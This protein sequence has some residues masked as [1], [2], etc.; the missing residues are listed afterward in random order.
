MIFVI[1]TNNCTL[2]HT[3]TEADPASA[4]V[5]FRSAEELA[6]IVADWP[7][8]RLVTLWNN[9]PGV[10]P[11]HRFTD[12]QTAVRRIWT[13]V[14]PATSTE[15]KANRSDQSHTSGSAGSKHQSRRPR[16]PL[17]RPA[18]K[19]ALVIELLRQPKGA[20]LKEVMQA[21]GWQAHSVRGFISGTLVKKAQLKVSSSKRSDGERVYHLSRG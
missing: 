6:T 4:Q 5:T 15:A 1:D 9:I 21:T 13:A 14:Q 12:R 16:K 8:A 7:S 11:V 18:S 3:D 19:K 20:T 10:T 2:G 17:A